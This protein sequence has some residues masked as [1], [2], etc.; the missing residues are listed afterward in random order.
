[1]KKIIVTLICLGAVAPLFADGTNEFAN[2]KA[3]F[4]YA[5]GM[6]FGHGWRQQGMEVDPDAFARALKDLQAGRPTLLTEDGMKQT[7]D[8]YQQEMRAKQ[9]VMTAK[10]AAKNKADGEAFLIA[11]KSKPG[12]NVLPDGLQYIVI[13]NGSGAT[14]TEDDTVTMNYRGTLL[15]GTEFIPDTF[16]R[17]QPAQVPAGRVFSGWIE[18]LTQMKVG[19]RWRLFIPSERAYGERGGPGVPPN[20][21]LI[22]DVELL[23]TQPPPPG[24]APSSSLTSDIIKVN[25]TNIEVIKTA[26]VQKMQQQQQAH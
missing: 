10:V 3:R 15:D 22:M 9:V 17:G 1:M 21:V 2:E 26:D 24:T 16:K 19:S 12:V 20:S 25:G 5:V 14:P 13:T 7:L 18:A 8:A 6:Y 23:A 11:N 4:S